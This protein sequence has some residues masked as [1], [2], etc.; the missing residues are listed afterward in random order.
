M[1]LLLNL[2]SFASQCDKK[3]QWYNVLDMTYHVT[4]ISIEIRPGL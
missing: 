3:V 4:H 2:K 1:S